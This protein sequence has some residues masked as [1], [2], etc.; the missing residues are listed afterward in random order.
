MVRISQ[1]ASPPA[2]VLP[3]APG[4]HASGVRAS[5]VSALPVTRGHIPDLTRDPF[6]CMRAL[7]RAHGTIAALEEDDGQRLI[8]IFGPHYNQEVL[9]DT[10]TYHA[11]FFSLRGSRNSAQRR[12]TAALLSMNGEEH[13]TQRRIIQ[14]PFQ[15]RAVES[16]RDQLAVLAEDMVAGWHAGQERDLFHDVTRFMQR[17]SARILLGV[18]QPA[19]VE[20]VGDLTERWVAMNHELG[21]GAVVP[22]KKLAACYDSLLHMADELELEIR[23]LIDRRRQLPAA[24]DVTSL[25]LQAR[26]RPDSSVTD[27]ELIGQTAILFAAGYLTTANTL[28][29]TSYLLAQH[30]HIAV[31]LVSELRRELGGRAPTL[32]DFPRLPLLDRVIKESMRILP[33][34][35]YS[36]RI[37]SRPVEL[38]PFY[39][40]RGTPIVFSQYITHHMPELFPDPELFLPDRWETISPS[41]YA[42]LPFG[43]GAR[44]CL[45]APMALITLKITLA[46]LLQRFGF[47]MVPGSEITG[48]VTSTMFAPASGIPVQLT[49]PDA[50][51]KRMPVTGAVHEMVTLE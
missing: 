15:K 1:S 12:L 23:A 10:D 51:W 8:F 17:V 33:A 24:N 5:G 47:R 30:P 50:P 49:T 7:Y 6:R 38:G 4:V 36:Q 29:W 25:L 14:A 21:L 22:H 27:T 18:D 35:F 39:L 48:R 28:A 44:L 20:R 42:Y 2:S 11:R 43:A 26:E 34:S 32:A 41:P 19:L 16:Y 9:S 46:V 40:I 31:A 13:K 37:N 45:G 3:P